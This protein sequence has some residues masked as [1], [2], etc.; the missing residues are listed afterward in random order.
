MFCEDELVL[1]ATRTESS[2][3]VGTEMASQLFDLYPPVYTSL[4]SVTGTLVY[5]TT[6][7]DDALQRLMWGEVDFVRSILHPLIVVLLTY[8][9]A[10]L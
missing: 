3:G 10:L 2:L 1:P 9:V 8:S 7:S 6:D 4:A 5:H